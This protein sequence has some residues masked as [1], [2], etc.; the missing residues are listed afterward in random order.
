MISKEKHVNCNTLPALKKRNGSLYHF[1]QKPRKRSNSGSS[2]DSDFHEKII[3]DEQ[4]VIKISRINRRE[5][6]ARA[7]QSRSYEDVSCSEKKYSVDE[8]IQ[9]ITAYDQYKTLKKKLE[10]QHNNLNHNK[11]PTTKPNSEF[12]LDETRKLTAYPTRYDYGET[13]RKVPLTKF[14]DVM[15]G[16]YVL[17]LASKDEEDDSM[18]IYIKNRI[19]QESQNNC[20]PIKLCPP[21]VP[22]RTTSSLTKCKKDK[23]DPYTLSDEELKKHQEMF[24][25]H[26][27]VHGVGRNYTDSHT[28]PQ[29]E[30]LFDKTYNDLNKSLENISISPKK[31]VLNRSTVSSYDLR[32][33]RYDDISPRQYTRNRNSYKAGQ[34]QESTNS[35]QLKNYSLSSPVPNLVI[36]QNCEIHG[37]KTSPIHSDMS[38]NSDDEESSTDSSSS[39]NSDSPIKPEPNKIYSPKMESKCVQVSPSNEKK[40]ASFILHSNQSSPNLGFHATIRPRMPKSVSCPTPPLGKFSNDNLNAKKMLNLHMAQF[41]AEKTDEPKIQNKIIKTQNNERKSFSYLDFQEPKKLSIKKEKHFLDISNNSSVTDDS[42]S[43]PTIVSSI[44]SPHISFCNPTRPPKPKRKVQNIDEASSRR[45]RFTRARS[46][47]TMLAEK[48]ESQKSEKSR[49]LRQPTKT[50][51]KKGV[52]GLPIPYSSKSLG[53]ISPTS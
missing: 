5:R 14:K 10:L 31:S 42:P 8:C 46:L 24:K 49:I 36:D 41:S 21:P 11:Y 35:S 18:T 6:Y 7:R 20:L 48:E 9:L 43:S 29:N 2:E 32:S 44:S 40:E 34:K 28:A 3:S 26:C 12:H 51:Y 15:A 33:A 50:F 47:F 25:Q 39:S 27:M 19:D 22:L 23:D 45:N 13:N 30:S 38:Q 1:Q 16:E 4:N 52:S 53:S 17:P 37:S